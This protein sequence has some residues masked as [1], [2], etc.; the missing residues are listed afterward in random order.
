[1]KLHEIFQPRPGTKPSQSNE[2][3]IGDVQYKVNMDSDGKGTFVVGISGGDESFA[4]GWV[5]SDHD[6]ALLSPQEASKHAIR[7]FGFA[8][9]KILELASR[10]TTQTIQMQAATPSREKLYK[11]LLARIAAPLR[12]YGFTV[13]KDNE[14]FVVKR[15]SNPQN[16]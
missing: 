16:I 9:D 14:Q 13:Y 1:M 11:R 2:I 7:L 10:N 3:T 12:Q 6:L 5:D 4:P 15:T 8:L